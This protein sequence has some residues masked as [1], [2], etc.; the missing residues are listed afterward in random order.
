MLQ[1]HIILLAVS[2]VCMALF[3]LLL[4]R[5]YVQVLKRNTIVVAGM[6]SQVPAEVDV[7]G[8]VKS[9]ILGISV[10]P[11]ASA[12]S[13]ALFGTQS[14]AGPAV[15]VPQGGFG[16]V[17]VEQVARYASSSYLGDVNINA[18]GQGFYN[19]RGR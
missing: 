8:I 12:Q 14:L 7:E 9:I 13:S 5:P 17:M 4:V 15:S 18:G 10:P 16:G 1:L 6:L 19:Q 11:L 2:L 3:W